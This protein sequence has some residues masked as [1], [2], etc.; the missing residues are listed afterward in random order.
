[1]IHSVDEVVVNKLKVVSRLLSWDLP[2][3]SS[4]VKP[5]VAK[6]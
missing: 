5:P 2:S 4:H 6:R 1:M 3:H